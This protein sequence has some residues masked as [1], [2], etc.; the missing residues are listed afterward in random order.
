[1]T[2]ISDTVS[3]TSYDVL[4]LTHIK[5]STPA[6]TDHGIATYEHMEHSDILS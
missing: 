4:Q 2:E 5:Y 6:I 3:Q 1:M